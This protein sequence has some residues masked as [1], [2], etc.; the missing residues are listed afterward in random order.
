L[1]LFRLGGCSPSAELSANYQSAGTP[2]KEPREPQG[3][4]VAA[5]K[6]AVIGGGKG[7]QET[8]L[9]GFLQF[10]SAARDLPWK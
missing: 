7:G 4:G 6:G 9:G 8:T 5:V 2:E 1:R 3:R 10:A